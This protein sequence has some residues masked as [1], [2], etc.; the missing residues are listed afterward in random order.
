MPVSEKG[1][2][3]P[4]TTKEACIQAALNGGETNTS[5]CDTLPSQLDKKPQA[6]GGKMPKPGGTAGGMGGY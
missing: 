2:A 3:L 6:K 1:K 5:M 4:Y